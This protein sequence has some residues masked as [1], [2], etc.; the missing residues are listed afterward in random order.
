MSNGTGSVNS[1]SQIFTDI[2]QGALRGA[3]FGLGQWVGQQPW[4]QEAQT[5][6]KK[7]LISQQYNKYSPL[8]VIG[9]I[10]LVLF[11]FIGRK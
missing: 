5:S 8:I 7:Q 4:F 10:G 9:L 2:G 3:E 6:A 1:F 11:L